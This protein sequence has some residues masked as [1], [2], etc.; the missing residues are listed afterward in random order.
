MQVAKRQ[1]A[2][3][4]DV[5]R[6]DGRQRGRAWH[7][8]AAWATLGVLGCLAALSLDLTGP[9]AS[10]QQLAAASEPPAGRVRRHLEVDAAGFV[11]RERLL[12]TLGELTAIGST[13]LWRNSASRGEAEALDLVTARLGGLGFLAERGLELERQHFRTYLATQV[14]Q[15]RLVLEVAGGEVEVPAHALQGDREDLTRALRFD[16]DGTLNDDDPDPVVVAGPVSLLRTASELIALP[17]GSL[18]GR[19]ALLNYALIDRSVLNRSEADTRAGV[20]LAAEP[21]GLV[22]V[23]S[24]SNRRGISHG[25][26]VGDLSVLVS[27]PTAARIPT[28]RPDR[29]HGGRGSH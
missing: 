28:V 17:A 2:E 8:G 20:V 11:S 15:A 4:V 26:F 14:H 13:S 27:L 3:S 25:T 6:R 23:T 24:F 19:L 7:R 18:R 29:G 21:A 9:R 10:A 5:G 22:L 12:A 16:S 1:L